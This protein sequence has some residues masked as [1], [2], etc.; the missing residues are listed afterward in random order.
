MTAAASAEAF[1][2]NPSVYKTSFVAV[3]I[4]YYAAWIA[5]WLW[6]PPP[7]VGLL[8]QIQNVVPVATLS[9]APAY[10][11]FPTPFIDL[12]SI[13][14]WRECFLQ[15]VDVTVSVPCDPMLRGPANYSPLVW[16]LP[17]EWIGFQNILAT[18]MVLDTLFLLLLF[19]MFQP[20]TRTECLVMILAMVSPAIFFALE[21]CNPD[22]LIFLLILGAFRLP[23]NRRWGRIAAYGAVWIGGLLKFYPFVLLAAAL[24]ERPS[25]FLVLAAAF[26]A[27]ISALILWNWSYLAHLVLPKEF[28]LGMFGARLLGTGLQQDLRLPASGQTIITVLCCAASFG[29]MAALA[30]KFAKPVGA[31]NLF[32]RNV[33]AMACGSILV[34]ACFFSGFNVYYRAIFLLPVIPGLFDLVRSAE[35]RSVRKWFGLGL[36]AAIGCLYADMFGFTGTKILQLGILFDPYSAPGRFAAITILVLKE[37]VWWLEVT[38][39]GGILIAALPHAQ[40][41]AQSLIFLPWRRRSATAI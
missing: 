7:L 32:D 14:S 10:A 6:G 23:Q 1:L 28:V 29:A 12:A 5:F 22:I 39:L 27:G 40:T 13:F 38:I 33:G 18:G 3:V 8:Q 34:L 30:R 9:P 19:S 31:L 20:Q 35:S 4:V 41:V 11:H 25:R 21:R 26:L 17:L 36:L 2:R 24:R 37:A 15:G 16:H